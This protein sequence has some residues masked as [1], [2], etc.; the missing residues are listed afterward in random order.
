[1][2]S[3][4]TEIDELILRITE[5]QKMQKKVEEPLSINIF[6]TSTDGGKSTTEL[7]GEFVFF[8]LLIDCLLR[9]K[10]TQK[11]KNELINLCETEYEGNHSELNNLR[12][13]KEKYLSDNV[14]RWYTRDTFFYKTLNAALRTQNI[15]MIFL[16]R[17]FIS[18]IQRQLQYNQIKNPLQVYRSQ[19]ISTD[20]LDGL[21]QNI[22]Q[23]ISINS[24]F[25]TSKDRKTALFFLGDT[26]SLID[27]KLVGVLFE[28]DANPEMITTKPFADIS[29]DSH[30]TNELEVLFMIG[31]IFRLKNIYYNDT[32]N[33]WI[34]EMN[35]CSDNEFDLK[36]VL[37]HMKQQIGNGETDL[38]T[39]GKILWDMGK[40][41]LAEKYLKRLINEYPLNGH[42]LASLYE[43]LGKIASQKRDYDMSMQWYRKSLEVKKPVI[44]S[45]KSNNKQKQTNELMSLLK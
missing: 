12:E 17:N 38:Q 7:N 18:D 43:D 45:S 37:L 27:L 21:K 30:F 25:S 26:N 44:S 11:D 2:K 34:I 29:E 41:D 39:L 8:Q 20:E 33:V 6:T 22:G 5:D 14:L 1:V 10:Y 35:L 40:L 36:Q 31:S 28:I 4:I 42:L 24:F 15:H 19:L 3:V 13:F 32:D 23:F 16:F 9:L